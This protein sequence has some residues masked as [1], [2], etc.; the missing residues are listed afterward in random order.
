MEGA[1]P[2]GNTIRDMRTGEAEHHRLSDLAEAG[3]RRR[4]SSMEEAPIEMYLAGVSVRCVED[5]TEALWD[6][7]ASPST[8][9]ELTKKAY[10]QH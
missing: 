8:I 10:V 6:S 7:K 2:V 1:E 4:E 9:G 3:Y 5:I